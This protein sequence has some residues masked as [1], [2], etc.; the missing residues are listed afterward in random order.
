MSENIY[1]LFERRALEN[2]RVPFI[3]LPEGPTVS[4][5]EL[6]DLTERFAGALHSKGVHQGDRIAVQVE[7][8]LGN[9]ALYLA[10]LKL[11]AIYVPLNTSYTQTEVAYFLDDAEPALF[12]T[13]P[14]KPNLAAVVDGSEFPSHVLTL[15]TD[16]NGT[17]P[18]L[19][20]STVPIRETTA[21]QPDDIAA[22]L[23]T[24]G[25]TGRPKG[26]MLSH[27]NLTSNAL[28]L[29]RAW[30]FRPDDVL[31][32]ALPLYHTHGLFVALNIMLVGG[33][34]M[35]MLPRFDTAQVV[36]QLGSATVFMGVPTFYTRL[37]AQ[38]GFTKESAKG[39]RL[40]ISGSAPLLPE[41]FH[42]FEERT[43]HRILERYGMTETGM[44]CSN[45]LVGERRPGTVGRPLAGVEV[46]VR[47][48][49]G[50]ELSPGAI[51]VLEVRGPNVLKGYWRMPDKSQEQFRPDGYF[52]T[53]DLAEISQDG[54]VTLVGR[55][56][57][58]IISGGLNV[59]PREV[60]EVIDALSGVY[61]SAVIGVPHPDFGEAVIATVV[62]KSGH[63]LD[64]EDL[65]RN[66][67]KHLAKFKLPKRIF[68]L[69]ELPRNG[70]GKVQKNILRERY[71]DAFNKADTAS[72][73]FRDHA[74]S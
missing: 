13:D 2:P 3:F 8:S 71:N 39:V 20:S 74:A 18:E 49:S 10:S 42:E 46:R 61:E 16:G 30:G 56:K 63:Q 51:G 40:F 34:C 65:L 60:E 7:K 67:G 54:Y 66:A 62:Q 47:D 26:A 58:L 59:Y 70:M 64:P 25:T 32:H 4:F 22:I 55:E 19:V 14:D 27:G 1:D 29:H 48:D 68:F 37:L 33:G 38:P 28:E 45:P 52:I 73:E 17:L 41:T 24:S 11:G 6:K 43:G 57:D 23:Y 9:V 35:I 69:P 36:R 50:A 12:V 72:L 31:L 5:G 44:N 53:G 15:G 21:S